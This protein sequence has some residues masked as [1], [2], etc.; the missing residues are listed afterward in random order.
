MT[1]QNTQI[2]RQPGSLPGPRPHT[3]VTGPDPVTHEQYR[4]WVQTRNQAQYRGEIWRITFEQWQALWSGK[5]ERRGRKSHN[6][7]ITRRDMSLPWSVP[8]VLLL[9]RAQ[10]GARRAGTT[11]DLGYS[12]SRIL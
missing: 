12:R 1:Q 9:T 2:K 5:W 4:A 7:C 6:L 3:W 10:H 8:N 11:R